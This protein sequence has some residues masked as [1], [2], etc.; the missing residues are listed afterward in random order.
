MSD[1]LEKAAKTAGQG[2]KEAAQ[3]IL[4]S[5]LPTAFQGAVESL[6]AKASDERQNRMYKENQRMLFDLSQESQRNAASN[7]VE[8]LRRAGLSTAQA[9]GAQGMGVAAASAPHGSAHAGAANPEMAL[10]K[11]QSDLIQSEAELNRERTEGQRLQNANLEGQNL[12]YA[13]AYDEILN[14]MQADAEMVGDRVTLGIIGALRQNKNIVRSK[15]DVDALQQV[16]RMVQSSPA[17]MATRIHDA[18]MSTIE[19]AQAN[20][21]T[22]AAAMVVQPLLANQETRERI[23]LMSANAAKFYS[24]AVANEALVPKLK[25]EINWLASQIR[26]L[27]IQTQEIKNSDVQSALV[28][29]DYDVVAANA[30]V[31]IANAGKE[32]AVYSAPTARVGKVL[33]TAAKKIG[34]ALDKSNAAPKAASAPPAHPLKAQPKKPPR[35]SSDA[36]TMKKWYGTKGEVPQMSVMN[37]KAYYQD[38]NGNWHKVTKPK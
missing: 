10:I 7:Q 35:A 38:K 12:T 37:G 16:S 5:L 29:G 26:H 8:G 1:E 6:Q 33:D 13:S 28:N 18:L 24:D 3:P 23:A 20:N 19:S 34:G 2:I 31:G 9:S 21:P 15:G 36:A 32:I 11:S 4:K 14:V 22:I 25:E 30:L 17:V 27:D